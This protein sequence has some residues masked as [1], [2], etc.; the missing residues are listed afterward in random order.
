MIK[1]NGYDIR[2]NLDELTIKEFERLMDIFNSNDILKT[3]KYIKMLKICG[4][5]DEGILTLKLSQLK[6]YISAINF[7]DEIKD[8]KY[9]IVIDDKKYIL[10]NDNG[11]INM[12][13]YDIQLI[14]ERIIKNGNK[15]F[16]YAM[17]VLFKD[18]SLSLKD[19]FQKYNINQRIK[20][21]ESTPADVFISHLP[22]IVDSIQ[23]SNNEELKNIKIDNILD[24]KQDT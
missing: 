17:A 13:A 2:T 18:D 14:E 20:L 5:D 12:Y 4:M 8:R 21:F 3:D 24:D 16:V 7:T 15:W 11:N 6:E 22:Y 19:N 1:I 9:D 23:Q 10:N